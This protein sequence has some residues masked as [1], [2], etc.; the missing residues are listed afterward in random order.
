MILNRTSYISFLFYF[1]L[2]NCVKKQNIFKK[3]KIKINQ[4]ESNKNK[5]IKVNII[6]TMMEYLK[7]AFYKII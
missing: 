6:F 4:N 7:F 3:F 5:L 2:K 1:S